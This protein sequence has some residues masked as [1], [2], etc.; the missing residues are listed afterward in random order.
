MWFTE[1]AWP[2]MI[3]AAGM[4]LVFLVMWNGNRRGLHFILALV[5]A[6]LCVGF[7]FLERAIVTDGERLQQHVV[8][9]CEDFRTKKP[10]I[11]NYVSDT[12]PDIKLMFETAKALV[13]VHSDLRLSDFQTTMTNG[14]E[15]GEVHFRANATIEITG[16]GNVGY[17]PAR[18]I[19][20]F[21]REGKDWKIIQI[22]RLNPLNSKEM[23]IL[24][25]SAG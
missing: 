5:F 19:L 3:I 13:T 10:G 25:Q 16:A 1:N 18:L 7:Y 15:E 22:K 24:E 23:P 20:T 9:L 17:Q 8:Q 21:K 2:P 4:A 12:R 6:A 14:G 11:S